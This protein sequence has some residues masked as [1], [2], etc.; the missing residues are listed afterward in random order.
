MTTIV[1]D[2]ESLANAPL[3]E[4]AKLDVALHSHPCRVHP[5]SVLTC[6]VG[7]TRV[8]Y[9]VRPLAKHASQRLILMLCF[10]LQLALPKLQS[11]SSRHYKGRQVQVLNHP[12]LRSYAHLM[13]LKEGP[14][15][16]ASGPQRREEEK[17]EHSRRLG[18]WGSSSIRIMKNI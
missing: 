5:C 14:I 16:S 12:Q 4:K 9:E 7:A 13:I 10:Q 11:P 15:F 3:S 2:K 17:I 18:F 8:P 6:D 1:P